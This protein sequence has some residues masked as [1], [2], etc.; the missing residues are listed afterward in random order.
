MGSEAERVVFLHLEA[1]PKEFDTTFSLASH[2]KRFPI[3]ESGD[4]SY[5]IKTLQILNYQYPGIS[6]EWETALLSNLNISTYNTGDV[7]LKQGKESNG[8]IYII[9]SGTATVFFHNGKELKEVAIKD[10]GD[11][12]GDMA[13]VNKV[14]VR[15]ASVVAT[16]PVILAEIE[17]S[18]FI[19]FLEAEN[20]IKIVKRQWKIR[21]ELEK[22]YPFNTFSDILNDK[23]I[24]KSKVKAIKKGTKFIEEGEQDSDFY[25]ILTGKFSVIRKGIE[26]NILLAGS[27]I[28]EFGSM[29][30]EIRNATVIA[31]MD[32]Y[33][34]KIEATDIK[35]IV[36]NTPSF[37]FYIDK[38]MQ[39]RDRQN[40]GISASF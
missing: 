22:L 33:I 16:T 7:I 25:I 21:G 10:A 18:L 40:R 2:G 6:V 36:E 20:R 14:K 5:Y 32:A 24:K 15:S 31:N 26:I 28:G 29:T 4:V 9:L 23:I 30:H 8:I 38:L 1:L 39:E 19:S 12:I 17:D 35:S 13:A 27:M 3:E 11:V 37:K 34:L